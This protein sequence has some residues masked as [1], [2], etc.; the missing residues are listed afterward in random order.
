MKTLTCI[1]ALS[2]ALCIGFAGEAVA[3]GPSVIAASG[4]PNPSAVGQTVTL[5]ATLDSGGGS[6][7]ATF[8][9]EDNADAVLCSDHAD[10]TAAASCSY[11]FTTPGERTVRAD[12]T[13]CSQSSRSY[14]HVVTD[15]NAPPPIPT[16][17]EWTLWGFAGVLLLGGGALIVRRSRRFS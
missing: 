10:G 13:G 7:T 9:D 14:Q 5:T 17:A 8:R 6:C 3:G 12:L 15:P 11:A 1:A 16:M 4:S 2:A